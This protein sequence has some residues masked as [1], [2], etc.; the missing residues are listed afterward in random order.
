MSP[1]NGPSPL[2]NL[3]DH[4]RELSV[5]QTPQFMLRQNPPSAGTTPT[6]SFPSGQT[7][8]G[9]FLNGNIFDNPDQSQLSPYRPGTAPHVGSPV[10]DSYFPPEDTRRPSVASVT[11]NASSTGSKSSIPRSL[12]NK[13]F[14]PGENDDGSRSTTETSTLPGS[15]SRSGRPST[16]TGIPRPRTPVPSSEVVPF[17]YQ[18][19]D[20]IAR[21]GDA[22]VHDSPVEKRDM[23]D[24]FSTS[25]SHTHHRIHLPRGRTKAR[26]KDQGR[27]PTS[28]DPA[29]SEPYRRNIRLQLDGTSS[30]HSSQRFL[31]SGSPTPS[32]ASSLSN[33]PL[34]SPGEEA[35][36]KAKASL[37][38]KMGLRKKDKDKAAP[39][40]NRRLRSK[41]SEPM[42][43]TGTNV[44]VHI[45]AKRGSG[46][47]EHG[48]PR[49]LDY[50]TPEQIAA[51]RQGREGSSRL[52]PGRRGMS[53]AGKET[54]KRSLKPG[55]LEAPT[56][57]NLDT[58]FSDQNEWLVPGGAPNLPETISWEPPESWATLGSEHPPEIAP[59][60][61]Q[62]E[63][64]DG[65]N[66]TY[67]IRVFRADSTFATLSCKLQASVVE[68]LALLGRKSFLQDNLTNYQIVMRKNGLMRILGPNERP[69]KIQKR[70]LEQVGYTEEDHLDEIGREDHGYLVR[71]TFMMS[72]MGGQYSLDHDPGLGK[73]QKFSHVD[74]QGRN[75]LTI[76]ITL[77]HKAPEIISLNLSRN[78]SLNIPKDFI[79]QCVNLRKIEFTGNECERLPPSISA[80]SR[81]TYLDISNNR[82]EELDHASL[83]D[84]GALVALKMS[85]NR[86]RSLPNSFSRFKSLRNLHLAS[87]HLTSFPQFI[88]ELVT[89]VDLDISFNMIRS[90][91]M[92]IGQLSALERLN[93]TN[94]RLKGALPPTFAM[95]GSLKELDLRFNHELQ[96]IDVI[97]ELPRLE[98]VVVAHNRISGFTQSF[99]K[100]RALHLNA[101]PITRF[102]LTTAMPTL[103]FLNL[104][105]AKIAAVSESIFDKLPNLEKLILDRNHIVTFPPQIGKLQKLEHLSC[106]NNEISKL[107]REIGLLTELKYLDLHYNNLRQLPG[108]IWQLSSLITLNVSSNLLKE[109]PKPE[110]TPI[111]SIDANGV[112]KERDKSVSEGPQD[113]PDAIR[114]PSQLSGGLLNVAAQQAA[115]GRKGSTVSV[116]GP[117]G[118][119]ASV[120]S[121]AGSELGVSTP[122]TASIRKDSAASNKLAYTFATSLKYLYMADNQLSEEAFEELSL[123]TELRVLNLSYNVIYDI[124]PRA[125][126]RMANLNELYLSGNELTSLPAEDLESISGLKVLHLNGN[127]FQT[128][129]AELG[130][131]R[132]L[133]VL[134][135]GCNSLKY[136]ISN[137]P[138]DWNW[139]WNLDLKYLSLSGNKRLE[140]KPNRNEP[141]LSRERSI[142][143]FSQL[144][145]LRILGLMDVTLTIPNVPDQTEDRRVRS[146]GSMVRAMSYGMADTLGRNEHLSIVDLVIPD[147]RGSRDEWLIGL[148]DGQALSTGGSKISKFL[149]E[150]LEFFVTEELNKLRDKETPAI[151]LHRAF[152]NLNKELATTAMQAVED[153]S[154]SAAMATRHPS[155]T[156][157]PLL[158][159]NDLNSG[160][161]ATVVYM[162]KNQL[163]V[164]NVGDAMAILYRSGGDHQLL[165]QKHDPGSAT[166]LE[167]IRDAGGWV[168]RTGKLNDTLDTSRAFGYFHLIPAVNANPHVHQEELTEQEELLIIASKELWEYVSFQSASDI[169]QTEKGDLMRAAHKL[170]DF[171]IGYGATGKIMVMILGLGDL[172]KQNARIRTQSMSLGAGQ[173]FLDDEANTFRFKTRKKAGEAHDSAIARLAPEVK[174]PDGDLAIVFTDIKNSTLLWETFPLAMRSG[175][176]I[177]NNIMRR[178]LRHIGG[179]EVKTEGDAFMVCFHTATSALRWCFTVQ[180]YLLDQEWPNE[181]LESENCREILDTQ[182]NVIYKGLSVRMG[183][184]WGA[185]V[186]EPDPI[187]GRMDYFG[188]MVNRAAR[189]S[190]EADGGQI[191]VSSD[192]VQEVNRCVN[193]Y[194][195]VN[196]GMTLEDAFGDSDSGK[197]IMDELRALI[198]EGFEVKELGQRKLKG[199]ENP[200]FIYLMYPAS[201]AGRLSAKSSQTAAPIVK[202]S[203]D[204]QH[205]WELWNISLR[206][207]MLCS[208]LNT[209]NSPELRSHSS[210][211]V[212]RLKET[213]SDGPSDQLLVPLLEHIITRIENCMAVL[214][215]RRLLVP[216]AP[217]PEGATGVGASGSL[218]DIIGT[219]E[220]RL[221]VSFQKTPQPPSTPRTE[222]SS[223]GGL[224]SVSTPAVSPTSANRSGRPFTPEV[225]S[226][227]SSV[228]I[229][230]LTETEINGQEESI[231][232]PGSFPGSP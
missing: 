73:L 225:D 106:F 120:V 161:C 219:L 110:I 189:I 173:S 134:D 29:L 145:K 194:Q 112:M 182:G 17:L 117:N 85:N 162:Q 226:S 19:P 39:D 158:S 130:K 229:T 175:I 48:N 49:I 31:R 129:P 103:K 207:E 36:R 211:M 151:A 62:D 81:L 4:R 52:G 93:A 187:T 119:K 5:L 114:R 44:S 74:L 51:L 50:A 46:S 144:T 1:S 86:L 201:L 27:P 21:L 232:P 70:L 9:G 14:G 136:N 203:V 55:G 18:D 72:R 142:T 78:L 34:L 54:R 227:P 191:T 56:A 192:L 150:S 43:N 181:I 202:L 20:D 218:M 165:T 57:F 76:P 100:L 137:W 101:N 42:L 38:S 200:E 127:K 98:A 149:Q 143:D 35:E 160:G 204:P 179:Y 159:P 156:S 88:C 99:Q 230:E 177:H 231:A 13:F 105:N 97:A 28:A 133:L 198:R 65:D 87:N 210:D 170:R 3:S 176:R 217:G 172:R 89:L 33:N 168:S 2:V 104:S 79:Q 135:V 75:L 91:P 77:Y 11:T 115:N 6:S 113:R 183:I 58:S 118:R 169:V 195:D 208:S 196:N 148:F 221:G 8:P 15:S 199:L 224:T 80:A 132:K 128:L 152:L 92:E 171:A 122:S 96:D 12:Y 126:S 193:A 108:E 25:S 178:Q 215:L 184:H 155:T 40:A 223:F 153:K 64:D 140:I 63:G 131:I 82:L 138:Y 216:D 188:P 111:T 16:P 212:A 66:Q 190:G 157:G 90:F 68:V 59:D 222:N 186:C 22:P 164:A 109:L 214:Y 123:L 166:E 71:F 116:Y 94:N 67:C 53:D 209:V 41:A 32:V 10:Q 24:S 141:N 147:F 95:L 180:K 61:G 37:W 69:L 45:M 47:N 139:N 174:P 197:V 23:D 125:L 83:E 167:R 84:H 228:R 30:S 154:I 121:R 185:P 26:D 205:V 206:L 124:P 163:F 7:T 220:S 102:S 60:E 213:S 107:P 146:T